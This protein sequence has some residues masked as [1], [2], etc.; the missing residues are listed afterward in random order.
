M[1]GFDGKLVGSVYP[2]TREECQ[3]VHDAAIRVLEQGGMRCD[4]ERAAKMFEAAGCT[5]ENNRELVKIPE[6]V[7]MDALD[8]CPGSFTLHGRNDPTHDCS[9]GTGEVHFCSVTGRYIDDIRTGERRKAT[10]RDA[11]EGTLMADA[12]EQVHGLYKP[13]MWIYDE[14]KICNSQILTTEWMKNTNKPGTWVYDTG[15]ENEVSDLIKMWQIAAGGEEEMR[16][17]PHMLGHVV[18]NP[19][20]VIDVHYT[21]WLMGFCDCGAP[22]SIESALMGGATGPATRAGMLVQCIAETLALVVQCQSYKPGHPLAFCSFSPAMDMRTGLWAT[23]TPEYGIVGAGIIFLPELA[24][25]ADVMKQGAAILDE[26]IRAIGEKRT[27]HGKVVIGTIKGD[28]HDIGKSV[29]GAVLQANGYDVVDIGTDIDVEV[30]IEAVKEHNA[31]ALGMSTLLTLP[32]ME[33]E[34]VINRMKEI[35]MRDNIKVIVGGSPVTQEFADEIGADAVGF[36][37]QDAVFK[38]DGL[39]GINRSRASA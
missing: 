27:S 39:M 13:V 23:G 7:V 9:I 26:R 19:P 20:R 34:K 8:E 15:A 36:D 31:D 18:V 14:E 25:A 22:L 29:V 5:L 30:F 38:L 2:I 37:A 3:M 12:L 17:K 28:I 16:Q 32:L 33:M 11:I 24:M 6:K 21:S 10:R 4:D 1:K 35:G